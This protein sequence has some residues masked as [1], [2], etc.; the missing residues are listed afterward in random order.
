[1]RVNSA[2]TKLESLQGEKKAGER[3]LEKERIRQR[4]SNFA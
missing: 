1:M 3:S 2:E 4:L